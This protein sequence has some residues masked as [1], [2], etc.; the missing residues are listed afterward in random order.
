MQLAIAR[1]EEGIQSIIDHHNYHRSSGKERKNKDGTSST[2]VSTIIS[3]KRL[4]DGRE[5]V[6]P[7]LWEGKQVSH[8]EAIKKAI[9]SGR[10][11]PSAAT[12]GEAHMLDMF[13]HSQFK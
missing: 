6:I 10:K 2:V 4:N 8:K 5:T 13:A 11:W 3:D 1:E 7:L 12:A 9:A